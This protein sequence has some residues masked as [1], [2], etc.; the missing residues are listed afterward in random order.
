MG[1]LCLGAGD[2]TQVPMPCSLGPH[3]VAGGGILGAHNLRASEQL[4]ASSLNQPS[5]RAISHCPRPGKVLQPTPLPWCPWVK[6]LLCSLVKESLPDPCRKELG[7]GPSPCPGCCLLLWLPNG[8]EQGAGQAEGGPK[9]ARGVSGT[10]RLM[11]KQRP[12]IWGNSS[13]RD[14]WRETR[15]IGGLQGGAS[16][17]HALGDHPPG[18]EIW[19]L[20]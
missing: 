1:G 20:A 14:A 4:R 19:V 5:H 16:A 2:A 17:D 11:Q 8:L 7:S 3:R 18:A 6:C 15:R 10:E 9:C 13:L 12:V